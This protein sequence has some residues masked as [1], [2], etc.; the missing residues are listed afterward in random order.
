MERNAEAIEESFQS[1]TGQDKS[2]IFLAFGR[3]IQ[4][5]LPDR[6]R[7]ICNRFLHASDSMYGC[8]TRTTRQIFAAMKS[9]SIVAFRCR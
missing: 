7:Q 5:P 1:I 3:Q 9:S 6:S 8:I 4:Q 2:K